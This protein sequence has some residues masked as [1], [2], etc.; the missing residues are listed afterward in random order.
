MCMSNRRQD[1]EKQMDARLDVERERIAV[2]IDG[3]P[4][5]VFENQVGLTVG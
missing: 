4:F 2:R 1:L 5:D 3:F